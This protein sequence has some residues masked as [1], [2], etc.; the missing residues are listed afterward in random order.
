MRR[1]AIQPHRWLPVPISH[2]SERPCCPRLRRSKSRAARS[3]YDVQRRQR[4]VPAGARANM[5]RPPLTTT[6]HWRGQEETGSS[7][8]RCHPRCC[9][10]AVFVGPDCQA[11]SWFPRRL[12][13]FQVAW[14]EVE[15]LPSSASYPILR[16][17]SKVG[18]LPV[19]C[20]L[21]VFRTCVL[22]VLLMQVYMLS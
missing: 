6:L 1:G 17:P 19:G 14:C 11:G 7:K 3:S 15:T 16:V 5:R 8:G 12:S 20:A 18:S 22:R 9:C 4:F 2:V 10:L 13:D 21:G